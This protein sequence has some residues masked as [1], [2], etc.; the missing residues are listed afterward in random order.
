MSDTRDRGKN[1]EG[2]IERM[3]SRPYENQPPDP[4]KGQQ[5]KTQRKVDETL[6]NR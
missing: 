1:D 3:P 4:V 5:E 6:K 2:R